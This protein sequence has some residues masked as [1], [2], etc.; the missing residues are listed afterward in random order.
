MHYLYIEVYFYVGHVLAEC[1]TGAIEWINGRFTWTHKHI[2]CI[3]PF[4]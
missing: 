1:T 2:H 3:S 4:S